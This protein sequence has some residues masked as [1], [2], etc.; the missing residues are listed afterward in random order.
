[1]LP[2][3]VL[4]SLVAATGATAKMLSPGFQSLHFNVSRGSSYGTAT[5]GAK[6]R[7]RV[8]DSVDGTIETTLEN[9]QTFYSVDLKIG[10]TNQDVVVLVDTG[11][12]DLW[13][14]GSN[15][16][17]CGSSSSSS[18]SSRKY[19]VLDDLTSHDSLTTTG[20]SAKSDLNVVNKASDVTSDTSSLKAIDCS[21]YGVFNPNNSDS[22]HSNETEFYIVYGDSTFA[23]GTWGY[24]TVTVGGTEVKDFSFAVANRT[25]STVGVLG[26]GLTGLETTYSGSRA[27]SLTSRYQYANLPVKMVE[28]GLISKRLYSLYLNDY[29]ADSGSVLFGGIDH[30]KYSGTLTTVPIINTLSSSG[31]DTPIK[32]EVALSGISFDGGD[33]ALTSPIA[34]LLDSGTTLT[35]IPSDAIASIAD[36]VGARYS[37]SYGYYLMDCPSSSIDTNLT[38]DFDGLTISAPIDNFILAADSSGSTCVLALMDYGTDYAILGDSFLRSAYIVYD[39]DELEIAMAQVKYTT[40]ENIEV[41][42]GS[43]PSASAAEGYSS[44]ASVDGSDSTDLNGVIGGAGLSS[45]DDDGEESTSSVTQTASRSTSSSTRSGSSGSSSST[46]AGSHNAPFIAAAASLAMGML[47]L[48]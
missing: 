35:Y 44:T 33:S 37:S 14:T 29:N 7:L 47:A 21:Q 23:Y 20:N 17:Y 31:Y 34:A 12:S 9:E 28:D 8:R 4:F 2:F 36:S 45:A 30:A 19:R 13:V 11:S 15:N 16:P 39:L 5:A 24:D 10:S 43:I 41:V 1:M 48:L 27:S 32:L 40:E 22:F 26:I 46:G 18:S 42:T 6:P 38:F 25:N 3:S